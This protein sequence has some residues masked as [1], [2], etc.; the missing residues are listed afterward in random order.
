MFT[1]VHRPCSPLFL[2][3]DWANAT[4][5]NFDPIAAGVVDQLYVLFGY[6]TTSEGYF[7]ANDQVFEKDL[8][9]PMCKELRALALL[10]KPAVL[11]KTMRVLPT[12]PRH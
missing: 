5:E 10:G 11:K 9:L 4:V 3:E 7:Y 6:N 2:A 1:A 8:L 12:L